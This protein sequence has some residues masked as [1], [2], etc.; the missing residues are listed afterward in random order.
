MIGLM[1]VE[2]VGAIRILTG[3]PKYLEKPCSGA[4]KHLIK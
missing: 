3:K 1:N 2:A 4:T